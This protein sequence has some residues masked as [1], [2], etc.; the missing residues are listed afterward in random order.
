MSRPRCVQAGVS[1]H[2]HTTLRVGGRARFFATPSSGSETVEVLR[3]A[4][5]EGLTWVPLGAGTNVL[6]AD[7]GF[8]GTVVGLSGLQGVTVE[9][10]E[11]RASAGEPLSCVAQ[12][13]CQAGLSGLEW[14]CGIPGTV[15]G[16]VAMNAGTREGE[17]AH[18]LATITSIHLDGLRIRP[19]ETLAF[20]Y[21]KSPFLTG[22]LH[23]VVTQALF[24]LAH[25]TPARA[26]ETAQR[27]LSERRRKFPI[28][29]TAGC[30]FRNPPD[31]PTAG[32]LLDRAGCKGL[33]VGEAHVSTQHANFILNDGLENAADVLALI[34]EMKRRVKKTFD[35]DLVEEI[36]VLT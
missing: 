35:V 12:R 10:T 26:V 8:A 3:W 21:R 4:E 31:G 1:L 5:A 29:A 30:T 16:A 24:E 20:G 32:E 9:G 33:R 34:E 17:T 15:G 6:F 2:S 36:V 11:L 14:A 19:A 18:V 7:A 28:G 25:S 13:A 27:L 22:D 23:E